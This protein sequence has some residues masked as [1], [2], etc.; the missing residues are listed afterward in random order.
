MPI[1]PDIHHIIQALFRVTTIT[2]YSK[3]TIMLLCVVVTILF[4]MDKDFVLYSFYF[5]SQYC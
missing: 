4:V 1:D 3:L 5:H 2:Y